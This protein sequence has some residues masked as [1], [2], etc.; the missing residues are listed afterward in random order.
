MTIRYQ[1]LKEG[2]RDLQTRTDVPPDRSSAAWTEYQNWLT[3]GNTPLPPDTIGQDDLPTSKLK[4][5]EEI[6]AYSAGLRN[7]AIRGR[8][9]GETASW[10]LKLLDALA[11][12]FGQPSP[13]AAVL[14]QISAGLGLPSTATS[15]ND[16]IAKVRGITEAE[17]IAKLLPQAVPFLVA[18][19]YIDGIRGKHC[20]AVE[21]MTT[22]ADIITYD[23]HSG[24]PV[25]P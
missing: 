6:N 7:R 8:S 2:V 1:I 9:A 15:Y 12:S 3:A 4:R 17:H 20:D 16:A 24:W 5:Q 13:F 11:I 21:A 18:E 25:I 22:V 10:T 19:A 23:W 14:P